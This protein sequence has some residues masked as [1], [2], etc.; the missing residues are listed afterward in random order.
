MSYTS[1]KQRLTFMVNRDGIDGAKEFA[2][3]LMTAYR[4]GVLKSRRAGYEK[5]SHLSIPEYRRSAMHSYLAAKHFVLT[6]E[7][8]YPR[9]IA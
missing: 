9:A 2:R 4:Q 7:L 1:E 3:R 6:D 8:D 5:P